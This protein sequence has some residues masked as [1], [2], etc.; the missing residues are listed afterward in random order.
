MNPRL[1]AIADN[2]K[3]NPFEAS[4]DIYH[5]LPFPEFRSLRTSSA[6][7]SAYRKWKL[8]KRSLSVL[9]P[10]TEVS[11]LDVGANA[12]FYSFK[13]AQLGA[14]VN[15]YEPHEHY[16]RIGRQI[17][18]ATGLSVRW[19]NK[20]LEQKDIVKEYDIAIMLSVFQ[21]MSHGN[22]HIREATEV[23]QSVAAASRY[24]F[25]ELGCNH[26]KST[27][28]TKES[29]M[30]WV[31]QLLQRHTAPKKAAFLGTTAAWGRARRYLFVCSEER[32]ELTPW[33]HLITTALQKRWIGPSRLHD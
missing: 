6:S 24:L 9:S 19:Y 32:I 13:F 26:G 15:A 21:W 8:I 20:P 1:S 16:A 11:V 22:E 33:Q 12:G 10:G 27:I 14:T 2:I 31:W 4:G 30:A 29:P 23:L 5:P 18:E 7:K 17:V 28:Y 3:R 25:F